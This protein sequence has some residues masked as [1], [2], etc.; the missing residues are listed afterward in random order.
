VQPEAPEVAAVAAAV[1]VAGGVPDRAVTLDLNTTLDTG[2][3]GK[4]FQSVQNDN[5]GYYL[6]GYY[7]SNAANDGAWRRVHVKVDQLP[8]GAHLRAREG[9]YAP[10]SY[11]VFTTEDRERQLEEAFQSDNPDVELP[12]AVE[13]SQF[14]LNTNQVFVP[15]SAKPAPSALQWAQKRGSR[16]RDPLRRPPST[17]RPTPTTDRCRE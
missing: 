4:V 16:H 13:T 1:A 9:Y 5:S 7:S 8:A 12:V 14:R 10:K 11:G 6:V 17:G 2:D 15:I 3:F